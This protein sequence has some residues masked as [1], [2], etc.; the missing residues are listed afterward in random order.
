MWSLFYVT[1]ETFLDVDME[2]VADEV[3]V[4]IVG[5]GPAGM[6]AACRLMQL[7]KEKDMELR[8]CLLEKAAEVGRSRSIFS[9]GFH[10]ILHYLF[11]SLFNKP[12]TI[13]I[14]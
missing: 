12:R 5:G 2:R 3:D 11:S 13:T 10:T 7:A 6:S 9:Y 4:C 14:S 8:V 1:H